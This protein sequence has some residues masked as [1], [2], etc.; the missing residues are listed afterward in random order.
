MNILSLNLCKTA[1]P[2]IR[3]TLDRHTSFATG[4]ICAPTGIAVGLVVLLPFRV[5]IGGSVDDF[6]SEQMRMRNISL[7]ILQGELG[8]LFV[9]LQLS[10][11]FLEV[12]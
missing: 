9:Q 3:L 4:F 2:I 6:F 1:N 5:S 11:F 7:H 12:L 10:D 8:T